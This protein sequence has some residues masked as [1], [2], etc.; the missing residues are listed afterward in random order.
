MECKWSNKVR[1]E[2]SEES[3]GPVRPTS[4]CN[5]QWGVVCAKG[6][7]LSLEKTFS[8]PGWG[9]ECQGSGGGHFGVI[10]R[11]PQVKVVEAALASQGE[12][13]SPLRCHP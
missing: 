2:N 3:M 10:P 9:R 5:P 4:R 13:G 7:V 6:G 1:G 8:Y 11:N 12:G